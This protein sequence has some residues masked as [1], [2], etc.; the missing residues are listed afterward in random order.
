MNSR[1][2]RKLLRGFLKLIETRGLNEKCYD[3]VVQILAS[4]FEKR[5]GAVI[6]LLDKL[7]R[8]YKT[9]ER[10][11]N[12]LKAAGVVIEEFIVK[13]IAEIVIRSSRGY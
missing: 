10:K 12:K 9:P 8:I 3:E 13:V 7:S 1:Q 6:E 5:D 4:Q 11:N 2:K